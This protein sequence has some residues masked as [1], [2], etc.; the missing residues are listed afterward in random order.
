MTAFATVISPFMEPPQTA[1]PTIRTRGLAAHLVCLFFSLGFAEVLRVRGRVCIGAFW[2]MGRRLGPCDDDFTRLPIYF[3]RLFGPRG[4]VMRN[5]LQRKEINR[6]T[7]VTRQ[8]VKVTLTRIT[9][10]HRNIQGHITRASLFRLVSRHGLVL[11]NAHAS[12]LVNRLNVRTAIRVILG[13]LS[14]THLLSLNGTT[15]NA[16]RLWGVLGLLNALGM[17]D[18]KPTPHI[19]THVSPGLLR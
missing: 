16:G 14:H 11:N 12:N 15:L 13:R 4:A 7:R 17:S 1:T 8:R 2:E 18:G 19:G 3:G 10:S 9:G 6:L 5:Q